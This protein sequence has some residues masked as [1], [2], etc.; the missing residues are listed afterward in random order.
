MAFEDYARPSVA[1]DVVVLAMRENSLQVL[2]IRRKYPPHRGYWAFPGGFVDIDEALEEAA[3]RELEEETGVRDVDLEQL[4]TFGDPRRDPRGRVISV[5]Y[6]ALVEQ[7]DCRPRAGD[8]AAE[9]GWWSAYD[10]PS[11]AFDHDLILARAMMRIR[12]RLTHAP[13]GLPLLPTEFSL[14]ELHQAYQ[15]ILGE[16]VEYAAFVEKTLKSDL[17]IE[18]PKASTLAGPLATSYRFR[19]ASVVAA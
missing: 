18:A 10:P 11:L 6:L 16:T 13:A 7:R 9:V 5:A 15:R 2:L 14:Q 17:L 3:L 19:T 1:V 12:E 4:H 8:D